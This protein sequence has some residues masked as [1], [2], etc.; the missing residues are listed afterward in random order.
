M[1]TCFWKNA[2]LAAG[3]SLL[4][5]TALLWSPASAQNAAPTA[6]ATTTSSATTAPAAGTA[7]GGRGRGRGNAVSA[8]P[9]LGLEEGLLEFD[10]PD[11]NLKLVKASQTIAAL[12]PKGADGFDFTPADR[13]TYRASN[14]FNS[15]GDLTLRVR[16]GDVGPW[17][18]YATSTAR[19][20]VTPLDVAAPTLAAAD[21]SPTLPADCP[22]QIT[23]TWLLDNGRLAVRFDLKNKTAGPVQ[24]GALGLPM[25]FNNMLTRA[26]AANDRTL[27]QMETGCSFYDPAINEDGGYVQVTRLNGHGPAL[28][29]VPEGRTPFEAWRILNEPNGPN[30]MFGRGNPY[31]GSFEW[32]VHSQAYAEN[33]W[34]GVQE[35]NPATLATLAPGEIK[36]YGLKF[37]VAPELRDIDQTL[38][39]NNRPVAVGIPGY[40]LPM[41]LNGKLFLNYPH[42]ITSIQTDP[43]NAISVVQNAPTKNGWK[44]LTLH[45]QTWGRVRLSITYDDGATQAISYYVIKPGAQAVAD[46]GNFYFTK[47]WFVDPTDPFGRSPSVMTYDRA[48][49]RIV[50]Q[51][52]RAWEAG[53]SDEGGAGSWLAAAMKESGQPNPDELAKYQQFIDGV[54]WGNIQYKDGDLQYGV[55]KSVFYHDPA[56][57]PDF[58]Y[59]PKINWGSWT[60]WNQ[61]DASVRHPR[62]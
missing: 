5:V 32:M 4:G 18:N 29:V 31:E 27:A 14:G 62:L 37:L 10:T 56:V 60:S 59:D 2:G 48:H 24:I 22:L 20:P 3:L 30:G 51:D 13:L 57:L 49:N 43:A 44:D 17:T 61:R 39:A 47:Q 38:Q 19:Q 16:A 55:K 26:P 21:L 42:K 25:I 50:T 8:T 53:L 34:Q 6:T 41:D 12:Q 40:I 52:A 23:R 11:F 15:L 58:P 35:W 54:L 7:T 9:T 45:G 1:K 33:E 46:L 28:L 36:S